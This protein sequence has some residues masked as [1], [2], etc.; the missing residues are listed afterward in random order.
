[1][2]DSVGRTNKHNC[3]SRL[4]KKLTAINNCDF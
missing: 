3:L 1:M 4:G 2:S